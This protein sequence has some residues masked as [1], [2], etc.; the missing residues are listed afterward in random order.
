MKTIG[1]NTKLCKVA[2]PFTKGAVERL[3]R[4]VK[5]NFMTGRV[6]GN[7]TDLNYEALRWCNAQ[8][9]KYHKEHKGQNTFVSCHGRAIYCRHD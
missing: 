4:F 1:F 8:N 5:E 3:V 7:I 2:H 9:G 6:F